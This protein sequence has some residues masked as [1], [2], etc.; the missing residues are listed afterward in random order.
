[1][2]PQTSSPRS[3]AHRP[4][5]ADAR[6]NFERLL[7]AAESAFIERGTDASLEEIARRAEVGIGTLYRHFP[8]RDALL[9]ALLQDRLRVLG[10]RATELL[11][12]PSPAEAL[13]TWL[14][15]LVQHSA[16][17]RGLA[18]PMLQLLSADEDLTSACH[19]MRDAGQRVLARAQ[20]AGVIRADVSAPDVMALANSVAWAAEQSPVDPARA[21]RLLAIMLEGLRATPPAT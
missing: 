18:G 13:A 20:A 16:T 6:R 4:S 15:A 5:R 3:A 2:S 10:Q 8:T 14:R 17:Y 7:A 12:A 1:M 21:E 11:D 9:A 19:D